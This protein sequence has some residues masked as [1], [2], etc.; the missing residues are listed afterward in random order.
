MEAKF[1]ASA[2]WWVLLLIA[3]SAD[4]SPAETGWWSLQPLRKPE[5]PAVKMRGWVRTP[6]DRFIL[7]KLEENSLEP[8]R[9]A[10][11]RTLL[12][13]VYFDLTGL[14]PTPE[15][16]EAFLAD[17]SPDAYE[18]VVQRLLASPRYGERWARYWLDI[19]HYAETHGHDQDRPRTNAWPWRD[20]VVRAFN[21]DKPY[22][23]FVEEQIAGDALFPDEPQAV[24]AMGFLA[25][26]PWDE[27]SLRDIREDTIDRQIARYLDRDDIVTTTM[28]TFV[29]STV[30][31]ARCHD[32]KFDPI[33]QEEYYGLQAVFAATDKADRAYDA[34]TQT[35][36]RRRK[37][38]ERKRAIERKDPALLPGMQQ[39]DFRREVSAWEMQRSE[40]K[41]AVLRPSSVTAASNSTLT[42][43]ADG[44]VLASGAAPEADTYTVNAQGAF[45]GV[46]AIRLEVLTD[47]GLP[48]K[49]PGRAEN[50]NFHLTD[51]RVMA[52]RE[53]ERNAFPVG[54]AS[55]G[56]DQKD[57][58]IS[59]A[60]DKDP[61]SG[62]GIHPQEGKSHSAVFEL[63]E[64]MT[65]E[66]GTT[67]TCVLEQNHGRRHVI[68]RFRLAVTSAARPMSPWIAPEEIAKIL[69]VPAAERTA[70][71]GI[72]LGWYFLRQKVEHEI[73]QLPPAKLIYAGASDF[74]A[75]GS[76][77][78]ALGPRPVHVLKRGDIR[79]PGELAT[80]GTMGC[81]PGLAPQFRLANANDEGSRRAALAKWITSPTNTLTWRSIANRVW[82]YHFGRG[83]VETPNDFGRMGA[84]PTHPELL[85]W[86]ATQLLEN[87]GSLKQLHRLIVSSAVYQQSCADNPKFA[88][89]DSGNRYLW[90]MNRTRLDAEAVRDAVLQMSGKL[91][92]AMGGPSAQ[93]FVMSPGIHV[94]PNV[95]YAKFD[96]DSRASCR[97]S[98]YRFIFRTVP[99][100]FMDSLDCADPSQLTPARN[101]SMTALQALAMLNNHFMV[102]QSEHLAERLGRMETKLDRQINL[103]YELALGRPPR[104]DEL[105]DVADYTWK[106]GL[107]N[108]CRVILNSNEFM[109]VN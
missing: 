53:G 92:L 66:A 11:K 47:G 34:D 79:R 22:P 41:W 87:G 18:K 105:R 52:T 29:S 45:R 6:V 69:D 75:D 35:H 26:G 106:H 62:W 57:W 63:K 49:G 38:L 94:T 9:G 3:S 50:G 100:P 59:K 20:Y 97:R 95:D 109:F 15:E 68:G 10:E 44:A 24:V 56:F 25:T 4:A 76:F 39:A 72:E 96:V 21:E 16:M 74:P 5:L 101:V 85:D 65:L 91:D 37:L 58:E 43:Q 86:L 30:Q 14:P 46:T 108:A 83:I 89:I 1:Q 28:N 107:A 8:S 7:A 60:I 17:R 84:Q 82:Q 55:A 12:R 27:S 93:Q 23:R 19:A 102:R 104:P 98:I 42:A 36:A 2:R 13:R 71:Q 33:S 81:V 61:K 77:K 90:R 51:F 70:E 48:A 78:P 67:L 54:S 64:P 80:P 40:I 31:C 32:H 88:A 73:A 103:L 99:D